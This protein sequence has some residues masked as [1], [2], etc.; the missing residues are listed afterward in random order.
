MKLRMIG[1]DLKNH[2]VLSGILFLFF[3][4]SAVLFSITILLFTELSGAI[5]QLMVNARTP[6]FLQMH[7]GT[8][9]EQQ[10]REFAM[11]QENVESVQI[12]SFLNIDS[13]KFILNGQ[14]LTNST[15]DNGLVTQNEEFDYLL[16][17]NGEILYP[18]AGEIYVPICYGLQ[19][20]LEEGQKAQIAGKEFVIAG[21]LRDSQMNSMMASSK[22]FLVA[23]EDYLALKIT[24][25]E[26]T[27]IEFRLKDI[28]GTNAFS[29]AYAQAGLDS[30]GPTIT[31]ALVKMMNALSDGMRIGIILLISVFIVLLSFLCIRFTLLAQMEEEYTEIG[32]MKA[33][34]IRMKNIRFLYL[35]KYLALAMAGGALG[36]GI[37]FALRD[38]ILF[39]IHKM[40]GAA[41]VAGIETVGML[42]GVA[43]LVLWIGAYVQHTLKKLKKVS[44]VLAIQ[45]RS[46]KDEQ[47]SSKMLCLSRWGITK[48]KIMPLLLGG[49]D[50]WARRKMYGV[51]LMVTILS[52]CLVLI[53]YHLSNTISSPKFATYMGI[54]DAELRMDIQQTDYI[55]EKAAELQ[56]TLSAAEQVSKNTVLVTKSI[57]VSVNGEQSNWKVELGDHSVFPVTYT[58]GA[59]PKLENE[60]ACSSLLASDLGVTVGDQITILQGN[61][62]VEKTIC[63]IYS[64]ITNGGKTAKASF[65]ADSGEDM[66][67]VGYVTLQG[68]DKEGFLTAFQQQYPD[69]KITDIAKYVQDTYGDTLDE[70]H[71]I[72]WFAGGAAMLLLLLIMVLFIR[73]LVQKDVEAIGIMKSCGFSVEQIRHPYMAGNGMVVLAGAYVGILVANGL[74]E[75]LVGI[76]LSSMGADAFSFVIRPVFTYA[77]LPAMI[78]LTVLLGIYIGTN[79][80]RKVLIKG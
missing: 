26:E 18:G 73:M 72:A 51:I 52:V 4:L 30:N 38:K 19:Y 47:D 40:Y 34:G 80:I 1:N 25:K 37:S 75:K 79:G 54:G 31:Y 76:V 2:K 69:M 24:G 60:I 77:C 65:R 49:K 29:T 16:G 56:R 63:G 67:A 70:V 20:H 57:P 12:T 42:A 9:H 62:P 35:G 23:A 3:T 8:V 15:Q 48:F 64:D 17:M 44:P 33:I 5:D 61:V 36:L 11:E 22:R 21:F 58:K 53:P 41:R 43:L 68:T 14:M 7:T 46:R 71:R 10:I 50:V 78:L 55:S 32:T 6:H 13:A 39:E 66:W 74:G 45:G 28:N 27:L 59:F